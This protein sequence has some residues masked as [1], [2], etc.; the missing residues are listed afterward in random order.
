M[1]LRSLDHICI[2]TE[3]YE[4]S[5]DFY[6]RFLGFRVI[7]E[8]PGFHSRDF[9][10]WLE[11]SGIRIELQTPKAG[12]TFNQWS[13]L[14]AG[15]VHLAFIVDDVAAFYKELKDRGCT[16]FKVKNGRELYEVK[17]TPLFK[18]K[19]PEGTEIEIRQTPVQ[20]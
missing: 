17:G 15:P 12:T 11:S 19:A 4:D 16:R 13:S 8:T 20:G 18:V 7:V 3:C 9:N 14:N 1:K 10:T 2:Q 5:L 6:T